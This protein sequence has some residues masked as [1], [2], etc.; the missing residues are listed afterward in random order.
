MQEL[1]SL[2][3]A[4]AIDNFGGVS[5]KAIPNFI[6][7]FLV[8]GI[9]A[10]ILKRLYVKYGHA[11]SNR[12]TFGKNFVILS[13]TTMFIITV[14]K[15]S[16]ALSLGLVGALSI[17]RFRTAIKDPEEL[18]YLFICIAVGLGCGAGLTFF[19]IIAFLGFS[20]WI[21]FNAKAVVEKLGE[22]VYL[23]INAKKTTSGLGLKDMTEILS[24]NCNSLK[25]KRID[26]NEELIEVSYVIDFA[27]FDQLNDAQNRLKE[28]DPALTFTF[29]DTTRDE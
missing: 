15:S 23:T 10:Y 13:I 4:F 20:L 11:V 8:C 19:T 14:V 29:L 6:F 2:L 17:V 27:N 7:S 26:E 28:K 22:T 9:L 5:P 25:L 3:K 21:Y 12:E 18:M 24:A 1:S 16:L